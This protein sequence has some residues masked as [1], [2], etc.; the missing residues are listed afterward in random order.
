MVVG[1]IDKACVCPVWETAIIAS[2]SDTLSTATE[3]SRQLGWWG[4]KKYPHTNYENILQIPIMDLEL[5]GFGRTNICQ[6]QPGGKEQGCFC[7]KK[8]EGK[9]GFIYR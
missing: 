2:K 6:I 9:N 3:S 4:K 8:S 7:N 5:L 1:F